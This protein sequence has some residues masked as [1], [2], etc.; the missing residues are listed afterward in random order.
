VAKPGDHPLLA[1][2]SWPRVE[3]SRT[4]ETVPVYGKR[5]RRRR[6][7]PPAPSFEQRLTLQKAEED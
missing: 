5:R 4:P 2:C 3:D 6:R 7:R 1:M